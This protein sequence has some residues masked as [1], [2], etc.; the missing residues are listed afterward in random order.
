MVRAGRTGSSDFDCGFGLRFLAGI[1]GDPPSAWAERF[2]SMNLLNPAHGCF[3]TPFSLG[4]MTLNR[5]HR[6]G[7]DPHASH[8]QPRVTGVTT[9]TLS[10]PPQEMKP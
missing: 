2:G 9:H 5:F 1:C 7:H 3:G 6:R 10:A 4:V 8:E